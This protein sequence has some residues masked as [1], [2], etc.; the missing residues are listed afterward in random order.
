MKEGNGSYGETALEY[1]SN[2]SGASL[3]AS[4]TDA[5]ISFFNC[6]HFSQ[7][8]PASSLSA[9][10]SVSRNVQAAPPPICLRLQGIRKWA[11]KQKYALKSVTSRVDK[12]DEDGTVDCSLHQMQRRRPSDFH[13]MVDKIWRLVSVD[14][15][16]LWGQS[17]G[18]VVLLTCIW[19][20]KA[21]SHD[22]TNTNTITITNTKIQLQNRKYKAR[23]WLCYSRVSGGE[24]LLAD[25]DV[26]ML[27]VDVPGDAQD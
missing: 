17:R 14:D 19:W 25:C 6:R 3:V 11:G 8:L 1:F 13:F 24:R 15:N 2:L 10:F 5:F 22:K 21:C 9:G 18:L 20:R 16:C 27:V 26:V 23:L 4:Y 12:D 7:R